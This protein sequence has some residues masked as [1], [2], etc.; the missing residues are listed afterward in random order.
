VQGTRRFPN[1]QG[2][3]NTDRYGIPLR[4]FEIKGIDNLLTAGKNVGAKA[5]A[6]GSVRIQPNT[7]LAAQ[8]IGILIGREKSRCTVSMLPTSSEFIHI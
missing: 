7:G 8:A 3:G 4:S 1:G 6:Y 5:A 2:L